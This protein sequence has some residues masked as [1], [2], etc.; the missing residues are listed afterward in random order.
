VRNGITLASQ[1]GQTHDWQAVGLVLALQGALALALSAYD[2]ANPEDILDPQPGKGGVKR[3]A[4]V[5]LLLRRGGSLDYLSDPE[6]LAMPRGQVRALT[7]LVERRNRVLHPLESDPSTGED[8][9]Q[10]VSAA[11]AALNHL[12][13]DHP[14]FDAGRLT[15]HMMAIRDGLRSL[16][17]AD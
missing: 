16:A 3:L 10:E 8:L 7:A 9:S 15:V 5:S 14:A 6:R 11:V 4:P 1:H 13:I 12:L 17:A 2:T